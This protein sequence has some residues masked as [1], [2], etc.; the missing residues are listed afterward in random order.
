[1]HCRASTARPNDGFFAASRSFPHRTRLVISPL[2]DR[3]SAD[4]HRGAR[5]RSHRK[6]STHEDLLRR[7]GV[8]AE[9]FMEQMVENELEAL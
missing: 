8:Y 3:A 2:V 5:R 6:V 9:I 1:M 4:P 7:G